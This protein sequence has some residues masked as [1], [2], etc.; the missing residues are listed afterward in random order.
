MV[1]R[2]LHQLPVVERTNPHQVLGLLE[3]DGI[4]LACSLAMTRELLQPHLPDT[5][6]PPAF[7][8][9]IELAE[10]ESLEAAAEAELPEAE[11]PEAETAQLTLDKTPPNREVEAEK[12]ETLAEAHLNEPCITLE[13]ESSPSLRK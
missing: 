4:S 3:E 5:S 9:A 1:G 7:P 8:Q 2:G 11:L 13:E 10:V 6:E 12:G